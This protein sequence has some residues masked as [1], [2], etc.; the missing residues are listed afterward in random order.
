MKKATTT[1]ILVVRNDRFG[2]FLLNIPAIRALKEGLPGTEVIAIV[3][4]SVAELAKAVPYI[5]E[6][7]SW[8]QGEHT[9]G[10][11]LRLI[12]SLRKRRIQSAVILNPTREMNIITFLSGI[13]RRVGYDRKCPCLLTDRIKDRK[14]L[15]TKHEVEYNLEL[16][17][18]LGVGTADLALSLEVDN[19][20]I[21]S[22][23]ARHNIAKS[24]YLI[25]IHPWTS[26]PRKQWPLE[27][28][29]ELAERLS[30]ITL[31]KIIIVGR[32]DQQQ[33][34]AGIF[35]AGG[36]KLINFTG[37]TSLL[38]LAA[39]LKICKLLISGDSGPVHLATCV[40]TPVVALFRNDLPGKGPKRWGP[41]GKRNLVIQKDK[42]DSITV[43]EVI[44]SAREVLKR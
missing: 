25:A 5:D 8:G 41:W 2:E 20:I 34:D 28:F 4:E 22:L 12:I 3:D 36:H 14:H 40:N 27:K 11:R 37:K 18:L 42:L 31:A 26:D 44:E 16:A 6:V 35:S 29:S 1:K 13:P 30:G 17:Q 23:L 33:R 10:Q 39:L 21:K 15:A 7:I 19:D 9:F 24:D 32:T 38:E 43:D